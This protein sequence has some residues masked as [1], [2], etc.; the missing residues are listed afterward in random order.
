MFPDTVAKFQKTARE[1]PNPTSGLT[2]T[3]A[4]LTDTGAVS[5]NAG[6]VSASVAG[7]LADAVY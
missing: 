3:E 1:W 2:D 6:P 4:K 7:G 5:V